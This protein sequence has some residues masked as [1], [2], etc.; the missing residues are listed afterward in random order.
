MLPADRYRR[1]EGP[2]ITACEFCDTRALPH[3]E[4]VSIDND[5]GGGGEDIPAG[6]IETREERDGAIAYRARDPLSGTTKLITV[7]KPQICSECVA[8]IA[9]QVGLGERQPLLAEID[10]L[11]QDR[12]ELREQLE[13]SERQRQEA[14]AALRGTAVYER[15][16]V[17]GDPNG[18]EAASAGGGKSGP[19]RG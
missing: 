15:M 12:D 17:G 1:V 14:E 7:R 9:A 18:T 19:K 11:R 4:F 3:L 6:L 16:L 5:A 2:E 13:T 10:E 8:Q